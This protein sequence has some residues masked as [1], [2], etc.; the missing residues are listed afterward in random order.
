MKHLALI[1]LTACTPAEE[2]KSTGSPEP[3][4]S[5]APEDHDTLSLSIGT[6]QGDEFN[7]LTE[8]EAVTLSVAPQGGY[9]VSIRA[10]TTGLNT[11]EP[12]DL[13]LETEIDGALSGSFVNV[14][15][16]LY[17]QDDG[18]GLLWGVV[19]GFSQDTFPTPDALI[20]LDGEE[21]LL[22]VEATDMDGRSARDEIMITVDVGG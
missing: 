19:V 14:G 2:S 10:K 1:A 11:E 20:A 6:G 18:L 9:G 3:A 17:C 12:I 15:T 5:C 16:N 7:A 13:L 21:A 4:P 8:G 22:I